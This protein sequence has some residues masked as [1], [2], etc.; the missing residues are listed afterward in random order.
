MFGGAGSAPMLSAAAAW[1][2][3]AGELESARSRCVC[4]RG[5]GGAGLA[6]SGRG[7][8]DRRGGSVCGISQR[9][10]AQAAAAAGQAQAV[11]A[12]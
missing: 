9:R 6:G 2:G 4:D 1:D 7:G 8:D 12:P 3:L 5:P 11:V 10:S